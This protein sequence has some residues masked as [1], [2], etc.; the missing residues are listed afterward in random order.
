MRFLLLQ[1]SYLN[2]S[3]HPPQALTYKKR[4]KKKGFR[5]PKKSGTAVTGFL[6]WG[7]HSRKFACESWLLWP[8]MAPCWSVRQWTEMGSAYS[9]HLRPQCRG[10]HRTPCRT[11]CRARHTRWTL[12]IQDNRHN[13]EKDS[14]NVNTSSSKEHLSMMKA[15]LRTFGAT[16]VSPI[17][18]FFSP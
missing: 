2:S 4:K 8:D 7:Q 10:F 13:G 17:P 11:G 14:G 15:T 6:L 12:K 18:G 1:N 5:S 9:A 3:N 16:S